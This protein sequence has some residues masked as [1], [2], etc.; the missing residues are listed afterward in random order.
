MNDQ[1]DSNPHAIFIDK[2]MEDQVESNPH[3][4]FI[5]KPV[6]DQ[7]YTEIAATPTITTGGKMKEA[8][9]MNECAAYE[10]TE[11]SEPTVDQTGMYETVENVSQM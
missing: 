5:D 10:P 6:E 1:V 7:V 3:A 9:D 11:R 4:I 2:P 8:Y